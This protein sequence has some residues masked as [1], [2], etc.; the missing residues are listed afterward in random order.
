[1]DRVHRLV[2]VRRGIELAPDG[3]HEV[4]VAVVDRLDHRVRVGI[5]RRL[6]LVIAPL[7]DR[8]VLPVLDDG[9]HRDGAPA[10]LRDRLQDLVL[11][12]VLVLRLPEAER[13]VGEHRRLTGE[14]AIAGDDPIDLGSVD[15]VV[16][17][18]FADLGPH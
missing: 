18:P 4:S 9:V 17:D 13:P 10:E 15:E 12:V 11:R 8:P 3:D 6:E 16:V 2:V 7:V 5:P 1:M 14:G